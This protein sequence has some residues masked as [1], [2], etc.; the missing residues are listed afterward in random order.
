MSVITPGYP[1]LYRS[2]ELA[3]RAEM[4]RERLRCCDICPRDCKVNRLEGETGYCRSGLR[5]IVASYCDHHGEE[6]AVS[7]SRGSGTIFFGNCNLRCV[8]CQNH[9]ISQDYAANRRHEVSI[10][11]LAGYMLELQGRGCHNINLVTPC[12]FVPQIVAAVAEAAAGGL[13][14]PL[15]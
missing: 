8:Y 15:V 6:P 11:T 4:L 12:H 13:R 14:I 10:A 3:R 9:Q 1:A 2:G 7:G 5:P